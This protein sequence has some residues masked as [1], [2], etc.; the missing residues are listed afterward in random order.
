ML[1]NDELWSSCNFA[2]LMLIYIVIYFVVLSFRWSLTK[3]KNKCHCYWTVS[4]EQ[5]IPPFVS[6]GEFMMFNATFNNML[7]ISWRFFP[8]VSN[9]D[10][11]WVIIY[12]YNIYYSNWMSLDNVI[13]FRYKNLYPQ[14][15]NDNR[16]RTKGVI[17]P[18]EK[19]FLP[20]VVRYLW[21]LTINPN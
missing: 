6:W 2:H 8:F 3:L 10:L 17:R 21:W 4:S 20:S 9:S 5:I 18:W 7:T 19:G 15:H 11:T 13:V 16:F 12:I 1:G 14:A